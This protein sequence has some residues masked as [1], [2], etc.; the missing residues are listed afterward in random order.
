MFV[1]AVEWRSQRLDHHC[2]F[3]ME[4]QWN[5][6]L[7]QH[8]EGDRWLAVLFVR[9]LRH[10][11]MSPVVLSQGRQSRTLPSGGYVLTGTVLKFTLCQADIEQTTELTGSFV[12]D[13]RR[14]QIPGIGQALLW[15]VLGLFAGD[16]ILL[17]G[18]VRHLHAQCI[19]QW[20]VT[21]Q[22]TKN[23]KQT[24]MLSIFLTHS[25]FITS[26]WRQ[27]SV[28]YEFVQNE[29]KFTLSVGLEGD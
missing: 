6:V 28:N 2:F 27:L 3:D 12:N 18:V 21:K 25:N 29:D 15:H 22:T 24:P 9:I 14:W 26:T 20:K 7:R 4:V 19:Y 13:S 17:I 23:S 1:P 8:L 16:N 10:R 11:I 5:P